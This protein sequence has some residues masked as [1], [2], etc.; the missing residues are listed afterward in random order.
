[1]RAIVQDRYGTSETLY[2]ADIAQPSVGAR[3]VLVQVEAASV[4]AGVLHLMTAEIPMVRLAF[5]LRKPRKRPGMTFSGIVKEVGANVDH[6]VVGD[7]VLGTAAGTFAEVVSAK[8]NRV[9]RLP[10]EFG[11]LVGATLP[12][13]ASTAFQAV[14]D[15]A[16]VKEGQKVLVTGASGGVGSFVVRI[17]SSLGA[18]VT[19]VSRGEK[20]EYVKGL[21]AV[22]T[23][24]YQGEEIYGLYD[25]IIDIASP[26]PLDRT[27]QLMQPTGTLVIVGVASQ[28]GSSGMA[29]NFGANFRSRFSKQNLL[30]FIQS[31][32]RKDLDTLIQF[33]S[34]EEIEPK[35]DKSFLLEQTAEAIQHFT[36]GVAKGMTVIAI[37]EA[38]IAE[39]KSNQL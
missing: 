31:E 9:S 36:S 38:A 10:K 19:A 21:G 12:V 37:G 2:L 35:I 1:M 18:E 33:L 6:V 7:R 34:K 39:H 15:H 29:R 24:D 28:K 25:C 11:F 13:S 22:K 8:S 17:A 5:G 16:K 4:D 3:E 20:S 30:W 27:V 23:I 32:D 14:V 26:L